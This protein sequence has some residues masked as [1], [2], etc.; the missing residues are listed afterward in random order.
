MVPVPIDLTKIDYKRLLR[1]NVPGNGY[2]H[3]MRYQRGGNQRGNGLGGVLT[4]AA[5]L[6]PRFLNS[7]AGQ[8]MVNAGK[9]LVSELAQ[10]QDF[11]NSLK[12]V[13]QRKIKE[14]GGS[15]KKSSVL[16]LKPHLVKKKTHRKNFL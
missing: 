8:H 16:V 5:H 3:G 12:T 15:G 13:A 10:G 11:K 14:I 2:Y 6:I 1:R 9:Q 7:F 4:A